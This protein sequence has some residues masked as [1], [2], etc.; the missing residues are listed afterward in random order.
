MSGYN[1]RRAPN[2]SQYIANL[3]QLPP[4]QDT[5]AQDDGL[6]F[7]DDLALFANTEFFDF[8]MG[9]NITDVPQSTID[10][11]PTL[12]EK[13]KRHNASATSAKLNNAKSVGF[14]LDDMWL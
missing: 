11:D 5:I 10:Y 8:D 3:N 2:V 4:A 12:E 1:G 14:G 9:Q 7:S 6:G 13:A